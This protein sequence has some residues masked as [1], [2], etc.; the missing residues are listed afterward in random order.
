MALDCT[1]LKVGDLDLKLA[2]LSVNG[3]YAL[4]AEHDGRII[5]LTQ[6]GAA[7]GLP[8]PADMDDLLQNNR[9]ADVHAVIEHIARHPAD[10]PT[11]DPAG[12]TFAPLV[13]RPRKI[14]CVGFN[15]RDHAAETGTPIPEAPPLFAKYANSLN[16]HDGV[17][18]L[19]T[20]VDHEFDYETELV[21]VFAERCR[22]LT[23][24]DAL[25]AVAGYSV[26]NDISARGL[27]N[28]TSQFMAG[29]M[30]DGFAPLGPWLVTRDR[31]NNPNALRL[32]TL[33]N[34]EVRQDSTTAD[35]IFD[36]R[37]IIRYVS[38]IMTI[39]PGDVLFTG[40]P[41]GVIWGQKVPRESR[42]WLRAGDR[43]V[44]SIEGIGELAINFA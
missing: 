20:H 8:V 7:I 33:L 29:K 44:S 34:G 12:V 32:Q 9:A 37:H 15:Y 6:A 14:V 27:Q 2:N 31:I 39:E 24:A 19:P 16:H 26:G 38:S 28:I 1:P 3:A 42:Q 35:M 40:T 43:V 22:N 17:V 36:C 5:N 23:E 13:T 11:L 18:D 10:C 21:V 25:S 30:S 4:G 41:P